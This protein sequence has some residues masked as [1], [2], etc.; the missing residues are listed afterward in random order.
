MGS[1]NVAFHVG[2]LSISVM[3]PD[4]ICGVAG[5]RASLLVHGVDRPC[6]LRLCHLDGFLAPKMCFC[7]WA[8]KI[9]AVLGL[10]FWPQSIWNRIGASK[11]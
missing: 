9:P 10:A 3:T 5:V 4:A 7:A 11:S 6:L 1:Y 2:L 8:L